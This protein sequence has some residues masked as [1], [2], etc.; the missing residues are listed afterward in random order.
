V[1]LFDVVAAAHGDFGTRWKDGDY[2]IADEHAASGAVETLVAMLAGSFELSEEGPRVVVAASQGDHHS[3]PTR[4]A[5]A[6]LLSLGY[7]VGYLG[8]NMDATDLAGYLA[9]EPAEALILSCAMTTLLPGARAS[10]SAAHQAGTPVLAGGPGFGPDGAWAY[11][12]GADAWVA[13][14]R[15]IHEILTTWEPD[16]EVSEMVVAQPPAELDEIDRNRQAILADAEGHFDELPRRLRIELDWLL[17]AAEASVLVGDPLILSEFSR[18]QTSLLTSHG[19]GADI[20]EQMRRALAAGLH[21]RAPNTA[22]LLHSP[23]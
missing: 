3:I 5:S 9:D 18:W 21:D 12:V 4:L 16:I 23:H 1:V 13:N 22:A 19:F 15:E 11:A 8:S 6:Y 14:P 20:S 7:R 10:V 17:S 2:R